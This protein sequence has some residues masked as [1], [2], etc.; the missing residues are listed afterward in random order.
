[1]WKSPYWTSVIMTRDK[2]I[3]LYRPMGNPNVISAIPTE[4]LPL[5]FSKYVDMGKLYLLMDWADAGHCHSVENILKHPWDQVP[6]E[7][8]ATNVRGLYYIWM[9]VTPAQPFD[10]KSIAKSS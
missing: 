8:R 1:M 5:N 10:A 9:R 2:V 3:D 6:I 4:D 7:I